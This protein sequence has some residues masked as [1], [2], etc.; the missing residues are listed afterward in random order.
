MG[1]IEV[2]EITI[3]KNVN[4]FERAEHL[5]EDED[6]VKAVDNM[7][8]PSDDADNPIRTITPQPEPSEDMEYIRVNRTL[9]AIEEEMEGDDVSNN[10]G[11]TAGSATPQTVRKSLPISNK[12]IGSISPNHHG[13]PFEQPKIVSDIEEMETEFTNFLE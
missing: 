12:S 1:D 10:L 9:S 7:K 6:L 4:P 3:E 2:S 13:N 11:L 5:E 8:V